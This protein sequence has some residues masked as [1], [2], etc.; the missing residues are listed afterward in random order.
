MKFVERISYKRH[1]DGLE[2]GLVAV[3]IYL[4]LFLAVQLG[5]AIVSAPNG[6]TT[7]YTFRYGNR[8]HAENCPVFGTGYRTSLAD[9][10]ADGLRSCDRCNPPQLNTG[11][12]KGLEILD[13]PGFIWCW[14]CLAGL[15][16]YLSWVASGIIAMF[17]VKLDLLPV[18]Q[19]LAL[20]AIWIL[21]LYAFGI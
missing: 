3:A 12:R 5:F 13:L 6:D 19:Y 8:Y 20:S 2:S 9:A 7:V 15:G 16:Y 17:S 11:E 10:V 1:A 18:R 14:L 21:F 4:V